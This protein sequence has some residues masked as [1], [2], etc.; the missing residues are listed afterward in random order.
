MSRRAAVVLLLL[1]GAAGAAVRAQ[2]PWQR[3][4]A[5]DR[6]PQNW[7]TYSGGNNG[8]RHSPL[9]QITPANARNLEMKWVFQADS[10]EK[11][12]STPLVV[13]GVM[14]VTQPP[15]DIVALDAK[16]GHIF[17][18]YQYRVAPDARVCCG[19]INRGL[20]ILG[21]TLFMGTIDAH[22]VAVDA[23]NGRQIWDTRVGTAAQGYAVTMAPLVVKDKVIIGTAGGEQ[24]IIGF[25]AG[26]DAATGK[27]LWRF[28]TIPGPGEPG[29]ETWGGDSWKHGAGSLWV[30][31][32]YDP[33]LNLT[34]W[35]IGNPGPDWNPDKRPGDNLYTCSAVALDPDTGELKWHFQF[36]PN[37]GMDWD[38]AQ[39]P[40]LVDLDWNGD[41]GSA[42]GSERPGRIE[43]RKLMLWANRNG[44]FYVLDRTNG[45]FVRGAPFVKQNWASGLDQNGRPIRL[46]NTG[47]QP[48]G[49]L[50]Y[51]NAQGGTNWFSPSWS[52]RTGLFYVG[53]WNEASAVAQSY[54]VEF[55]EGRGYTGG[56][57]SSKMPSIR[58]PRI[59][60][61][62]ETAGHGE[63][64]A[65]DP[66]T[67]NARWRFVMHDV[68]DAGI[69]TTGGN[70]LF[71]GNR[72][73]YIMALDARDGT[74]LWQKL[75]SGQISSSPISYEVDGQQFVA[76]SAYHGVFV[77]GLR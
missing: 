70:V 24:G 21:D 72:E 41:S 64:L 77:F 7:L 15:N 27:Q 52:P 63:I 8:W 36:T 44:F 5:A 31:G 4:L 45:K 51:P 33:D 58:R 22:L 26:F 61:W 38:S 32:S 75:L 55:V 37:D 48:G 62:T 65:L 46:L 71:A 23:K 19:R 11:L 66:R 53:A 43:R 25:I 2:V 1:I 57:P 34:Y 13:D 35:G 40:V 28:N 29:N 14:Y 50:T 18:I 30:T 20:A 42:A 3:L 74:V 12:E 9:T 16:T 76:L 47:S 69:L 49:T 67:G 73:G 10:T 39:V 6:E 56:S 17:W 59:N 60:T 68:T 54:P